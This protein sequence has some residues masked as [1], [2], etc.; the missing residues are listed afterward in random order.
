MLTSREEPGASRGGSRHLQED[1]RGG[2]GGHPPPCA[3]SPSTLAAAGIGGCAAL[4]G[5]SL[6]PLTL[7]V[8]LGAL[9]VGFGRG[10][11][12]ALSRVADRPRLFAALSGVYIPVFLIDLAISSRSNPVHALVRLVVFLL[13]VEVLS[14][15]TMRAHRLVLLG[16]LLLVSTAAETTEIW[17]A[18]PL[19][20]FAVAST[21][22]LLGATLIAHQP[23]GTAAPARR[24]APTVVIVS[25]SLVMGTAAFFAIPRFGAGWGREIAGVRQTAPLETGLAE[26]VHL[27]AVGRVKKR[28]SVAFSARVHDQRIDPE[29]LY[30]RART[31]AVWTGEGWTRDESDRGAVLVTPAESLVSLP[32]RDRGEDGE[33]ETSF[34][35]ETGRVRSPALVAPG[36]AAWV[37]TPGESTIRI[38]LDG[39]LSDPDGDAPRRYEIGVQVPHGPGAGTEPDIGFATPSRPAGPPAGPGSRRRANAHGLGSAQAETN[40][41]EDPRPFPGDPEADPV[42]G[43]YLQ[44]GPIERRIVDWAERVA[45]GAS[46]PQEI[47]RAFVAALS[48]R[49]YSLDTSAVDP[50]HPVTSFLEGAPAHCEY[51][52]SAMVLGLRTRGIPSR[53][54]GGYLG[55]ERSS[56]GG[57]LVVRESRAHLWVEVHVPGAGW[58][59]FDP[60]PEAGRVPPS[61]WTYT[62][63]DVW[64]S[65]VRTWDGSVVGLGLADQAN[66]LLRVRQLARGLYRIMVGLAPLLALAVPVA[67]LLGA[68]HARRA[69]RP[70]RSAI[71][72][73]PRSYGR[74]LA[75]AARRGINPRPVETAREFALRAGPILGDADAVWLVSRLYERERFG[76]RV[77]TRVEEHAASEAL[78]R[79][80]LHFP[81]LFS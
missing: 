35:I 7:S 2:P 64:E 61:S 38:G 19:V 40:L 48:T 30:W 79:L 43:V 73:V 37:R 32:G 21:S 68:A 27:G 49:S 58:V 62:L 6:G 77:P 63:R 28:R 57:A 10:R 67:V 42:R 22:A 3:Y 11:G 18:I 29:S 76:G 16:L 75:L 25:G 36:R 44:A 78:E 15:N 9:A 34:E 5:G 55:A 12:W 72:R 20:A 65:I 31:Y 24:W 54:V 1:L 81:P 46:D 66:L 69:Q 13:V 74:L 56:H 4:A 70:S 23:A 17:F 41:G 39:T 33:R 50:S 47:A 80:R 53:V 45:R 59:I 52:A 71:R 51:F 26:T 14:G 8:I 60:T